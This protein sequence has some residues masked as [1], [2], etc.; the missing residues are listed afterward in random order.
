[1]VVRSDFFNFDGQSVK[2]ICIWARSIGKCHLHMQWKSPSLDG[3][4]TCAEQTSVGHMTEFIT[5]ML[6]LIWNM[7]LSTFTC[8]CFYVCYIFCLY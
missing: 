5:N 1:V 6:M 7:C 4:G 2:V 8:M 3:I